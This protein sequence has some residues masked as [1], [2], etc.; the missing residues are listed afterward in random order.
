MNPGEDSIRRIGSI[1]LLVAFVLLDLGQL[2]YRCEFSPPVDWSR[3]AIGLLL[4]ASV[5]AACFTG[6]RWFT[7]LPPGVPFLA[8]VL[9]LFLAMGACIAVAGAVRYGDVKGSWQWRS[10]SQGYACPSPFH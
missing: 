4:Q 5:L 1:A 9:V 7:R 6:D 8:A 10:S 3:L 2:A